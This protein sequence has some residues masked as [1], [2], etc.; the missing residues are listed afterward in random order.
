MRLTAGIA[1]ALLPPVARAQIPESVSRNPCARHAPEA[2]KHSGLPVNTILRVMRAESGGQVRALSPR[3]AMGCMQIMPATWRELRARHGLGSDPYD[4]RMNMIGGALYL[5]ELA[6]QFGFPGAY[7]AYNAGPGRYQRHLAGA[8]LPS[9][10]LRYTRQLGAGTPAVE[11]RSADRWQEAPLFAAHASNSSPSSLSAR[12]SAD[13]EV[14]QT[15]TLFPLIAAA[16]D[17]ATSSDR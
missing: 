9:E 1:I 13:S 14:G 15:Q 2:A 5:A 16:T 10:T 11:L 12:R 3:G 4:A 17:A 7:A 8:P 6:R